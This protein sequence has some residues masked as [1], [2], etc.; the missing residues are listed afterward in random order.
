MR[1]QPC[2]LCGT[3]GAFLSAPSR[4]LELDYYECEHCGEIWAV[5]PADPAKSP[6][7]VAGK[8]R[9]SVPLRKPGA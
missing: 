2:P 6:R 9:Q 5:D 8:M 4:R 1:S 3:A 7:L